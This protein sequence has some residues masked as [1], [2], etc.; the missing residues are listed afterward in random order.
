M[1]QQ[2]PQL[3]TLNFDL[4]G[5]YEFQGGLGQLCC[6][7]YGEQMWMRGNIPRLPDYFNRGTQRA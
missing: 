5:K 4:G 6:E 3:S 1:D 7:W 2:S